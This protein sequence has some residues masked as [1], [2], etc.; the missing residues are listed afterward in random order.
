MEAESQL[1][2]TDMMKLRD[3]LSSALLVAAKAQSTEN[4]LFFQMI[5]LRDAP[6]SSP[7]ELQ[8]LLTEIRAIPALEFFDNARQYTLGRCKRVNIL[9]LVGWLISR[10]QKVGAESAVNDLAQYIDTEFIEL[11]EVLAIDGFL[12]EQSIDLGDYKLV[13]WNDLP[14]TDTKWKIQARELFSGLSPSAA[15]IRR[16]QI[17]RTH[18]HPW[19][20]LP[21]RIPSSIEPALDILRCAT[22]VAGAGF[23]LLH[24]WFEPPDWASWKVIL[25]NFGV[26]FT[27]DEIAVEICQDMISQLQN[28]VLNFRDLDENRRLRFLIPLDRLNRSY[29]ATLNTDKAIELGIAL[30]SLYAPTKLSRGIERTLQTRAARFLGGS[31]DEQHE[32]AKKVKKVYELRSGAVHSGRFDVDGA[33]KKSCDPS[34]VTQV[35]EEGQRVV[36]QSLVKMIQEGE[37]NWE[38]F[39][40]GKVEEPTT[41]TVDGD[42]LA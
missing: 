19:D 26:D 9:F 42:S 16:H 40:I 20:S 41:A 31:L 23:R 22:A 11:T 12:V 36:G 18:F 14:I 38:D 30:E 39:D 5:G 13:D 21:D 29:L 3:A 1:T 17:K 15:V 2:P 24:Y 6:A 7:K 10:G 27:A 4:G 25:S 35:L 28:C 34:H 8:A 32:T 33:S 37:P